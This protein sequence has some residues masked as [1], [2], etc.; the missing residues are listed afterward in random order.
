MQHSQVSE[1]VHGQQTYERV[2]EGAFIFLR[3]SYEHPDFPD[4]MALLR[5][6]AYH[7]FD[8]RGIV[9]TFELDVTGVDW[10]ILRRDTDFWQRARTAFV[11]ADR[12][13]GVGENSYDEG[14]TW[15]RDFT[16][17]YER[18]G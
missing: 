5:D 6:Q 9:R 16:M 15:E 2:L 11:D 13:E 8:V 10:S 7:Y 14:V 17:T 3:W 4:A 1:P 12:M 18:I